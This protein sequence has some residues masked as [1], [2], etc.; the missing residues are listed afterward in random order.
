M[1]VLNPAP[2]LKVRDG[3]GE[4][5]RLIGKYCGS[6]LPAPIRSTSNTLWVRFKS[7]SSVQEAGFR[8]AYT[9]GEG[10]CCSSTHTHRKT[11][12]SVCFVCIRMA[13]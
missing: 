3:R 5:D 2:S 6:T 10:A 8:A 12:F 7:D 1:Y 11:L 13:C 4:T 9:V